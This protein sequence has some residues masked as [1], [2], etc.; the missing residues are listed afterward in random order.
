MLYLIV[1]RYHESGFGRTVEKAGAIVGIF[2]LNHSEMV[3]LR[4]TNTEI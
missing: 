4:P 2:A 3:G 1:C